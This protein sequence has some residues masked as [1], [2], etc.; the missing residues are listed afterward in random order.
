MRAGN[1]VVLVI[2]VIEQHDCVV[3]LD[4]HSQVRLVLQILFGRCFYLVTEQ[5]T[6]LMNDA[7]TGPVDLHRPPQW[8]CP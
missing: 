4:Q 3:P 6:E 5:L 1:I 2:D 8:W 7:N